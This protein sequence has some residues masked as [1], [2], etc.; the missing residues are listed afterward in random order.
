ML[1]ERSRTVLFQVALS[2]IHL[3]GAAIAGTSDSGEVIAALQSLAPACSDPDELMCAATSTYGD[4]SWERL[5]HLYKRAPPR[6]SRPPVHTTPVGH[7]R[8][9][10]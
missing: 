8:L 2:L 3:R 9:W 1:L 5:R 7:T 6:P 4:V 10:Q